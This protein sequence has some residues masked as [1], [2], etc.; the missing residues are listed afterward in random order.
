VSRTAR[1]R[2]TSLVIATVA[3]ATVALWRGWPGV[4]GQAFWF[5]LAA[6]AAGE[7]LWVRL[8]VGGATLSMASCFNYAAL[9]VLPPGEAMLATAAATLV[10]EPLVMRKPIERA[11]F[12]AAQTMLAVLAATAAFDALS[13]GGRDLVSM[14]SRLH[15]LPFVAAA[16]A[17]YA[18][19]RALVVT[20]VAWSGGITLD[21]AWRRNFGSVYEVMSAGAV[22]SL[23]ALLATHYAGIGMAGTLF[24]LLPLVLACDGLRRYTDRLRSDSDRGDDDQRRAA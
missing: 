4:P 21:Q 16:M 19:N 6:C 5:W 14:F 13:G 15:L 22:L 8:P 12:N 9:L 10:M 1:I 3:G 17:Y 7:T 2:T 20:V 23:G 24:V 18:I 11:L